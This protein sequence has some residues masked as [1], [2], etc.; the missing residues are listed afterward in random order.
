MKAQHGI[1]EL[2]PKNLRRL[3]TRAV[4]P[5]GA[6]DLDALKRDLA[7]PERVSLHFD[8][9]LESYA[10]LLDWESR[11]ILQLAKAVYLHERRSTESAYAVIANAIG[12]LEEAM[13]REETSERAA[14]ALR[15]IFECNMKMP[16]SWE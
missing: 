11:F 1:R 8:R 12:V 3:V 7:S 6:S 2:V 9:A 13:R 5:A 10:G 4:R 14:V 15:E 16:K